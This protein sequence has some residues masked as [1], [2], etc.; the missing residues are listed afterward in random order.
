MLQL[1]EVIIYILG[2][3]QFLC[4]EVT[5]EK[6]SFHSIPEFYLLVFD[7]RTLI[8]RTGEVLES[9]DSTIMLASVCLVPLNTNPEF[10]LAVCWDALVL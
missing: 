4:S 9:I 7:H 5:F 3:M 2:M 6:G 1:F 8:G 10:I